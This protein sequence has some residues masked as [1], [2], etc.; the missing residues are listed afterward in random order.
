MSTPNDIDQNPLG[1]KIIELEA[2]QLPRALEDVDMAIIN[3][4]FS[5][6]AGLDPKKD[7]IFQE[8]SD[9]YYVNI[10]AVRREDK[11]APWVKKLLNAVQNDEVL[12][13]A[14]EIFDGA[15]QPGWR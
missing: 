9:S 5:K 3:T 4:T 8:G 10:I 6:S 1:L 12:K 11:D 13:A 2:A 7:G 15:V 14:D